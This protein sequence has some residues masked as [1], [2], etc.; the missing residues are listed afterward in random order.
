MTDSVRRY[1]LHRLRRAALVN[2]RMALRWLRRAE[3]Q[4][5]SAVLRTLRAEVYLRLDRGDEAFVAS[6]DAV[7]LAGPPAHPASADFLA[8]VAVMADA[9]CWIG[10]PQALPTCDDFAKVSA[11]SELARSAC[12]QALQAVAVYQWQD[13]LRGRE[14][15]RRAEVFLRD[16]GHDAV[17]AMIINGRRMMA[18]GCE[19]GG[20]R[21]DPTAWT[22][23]PGGQL[24]P[25][26]L[27]WSHYLTSR[28]RRRPGTHTCHPPPAPRPARPGTRDM[29]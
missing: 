12:A 27:A 3:R 25:A 11:G 14:Y 9:G 29:P 19:S 1:S 8:A 10:Q 7:T 24:C 4:R 13:C 21:I 2:P 28:L 18:L 26:A 20:Y 5:P 23:V 16:S 17:Q 22:P 6:V 15:L